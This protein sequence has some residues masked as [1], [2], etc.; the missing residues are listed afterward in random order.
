MRHLRGAIMGFWSLRISTYRD[1]RKHASS[2]Q[3]LEWDVFRLIAWGAG[4]WAG[5]VVDPILQGQT[6]GADRQF[7]MVL[8]TFST[9]LAS[10]VLAVMANTGKREMSIARDAHSARKMKERLAWLLSDQL[11]MVVSAL[12]TA[13]SGLIWLLCVAA[14][15]RPAVVTATVTAF[16]LLALIN[17]LRLPV[18]IWELQST[19]LSDELDR[20][21]DRLNKET[22]EKFK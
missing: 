12:A 17:A 10:F 19:S 11:I 15:S 9:F 1:A 5:L 3:L 20:T 16:G 8:C 18:Q 4:F 7:V 13:G 22:D 2:R 6:G 21:I 14:G